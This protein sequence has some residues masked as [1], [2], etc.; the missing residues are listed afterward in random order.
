MTSPLIGCNAPPKSTP[1]KS[2]LSRLK[3][4]SHDGRRRKQ[5]RRAPNPHHPKTAWKLRTNCL[6]LKEIGKAAQAAAWAF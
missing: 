3:A 5:R 1:T 6:K 4:Y 2:A